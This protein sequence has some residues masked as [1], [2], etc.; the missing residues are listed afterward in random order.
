MRLRSAEL[1]RTLEKHSVTHSS[2]HPLRHVSS[3]AQA[4]GSAT[5]PLP[6]LAPPR[7]S[8]DLSCSRSPAGPC[9]WSP[10]TWRRHPT[11]WHTCGKPP[12]RWLKL[13]GL[14]GRCERK[15]ALSIL[16][17][18]SF[19]LG[20][21]VFQPKF[22]ELLEQ[23]FESSF[24]QSNITYFGVYSLLWYVGMSCATLSKIE[25]FDPLSLGFLFDYDMKLI[26]IKAI[27]RIKP[28]FTTIKS[29]HL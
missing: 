17:A 25:T 3:L 2:P 9:C 12:Q 7:G 4:P 23:Y 21:I 27:N 5:Y 11:R 20:N 22:D 10:S 28:T 26:I 14:E 29:F 8:S 19:I 16:F 15:A 6:H 24:N 13:R 18:R 1:L